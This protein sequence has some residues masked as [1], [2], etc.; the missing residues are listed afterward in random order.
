[1][2]KIMFDDRN[3]LT[4][5]VLDGEKTMT[6]RVQK[7]TKPQYKYDEVVAI[8]QSYKTIFKTDKYWLECKCADK[9]IR[10]DNLVYEAGWENK[11]Y[12]EAELMP[13]R[14]RIKHV[15]LEYM[16]DIS[17]E[18][19]LK[20]GIVNFEWIQH[21]EPFSDKTVKH[22]CYSTTKCRDAIL[23]H[24]GTWNYVPWYSPTAKDAFASLVGRTMGKKAWLDNPWVY[25]YSFE[26]IW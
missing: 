16:Q 14:I 18:D 2:K 25:V 8:A 3:G 17:K 7:S 11:M 19:C 13:H 5:A 9:G 26:L 22:D 24:K 15:G 21:P 12:V 4:Q 1:M 10:V 6:R 20:E 23:N